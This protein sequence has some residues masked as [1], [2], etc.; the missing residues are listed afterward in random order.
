MPID[1]FAALNAM[2]RAEVTR[3][4]EDRDDRRRQRTA[5]DGREPK[6]PASRAEPAPL[7]TRGAPDDGAA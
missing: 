7:L 2:L 1:P 4:A 6:E 3:A 5:A